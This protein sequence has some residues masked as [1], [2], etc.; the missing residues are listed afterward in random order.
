MA[1]H[2]AAGVLLLTL[3]VLAADAMAAFIV[4]VG[5]VVY[6][7][8]TKYDWRSGRRS[9]IRTSRPQPRRRSLQ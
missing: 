2:C 8:G 6:V 7:D 4:R 5:D 3:C 9:A 1:R